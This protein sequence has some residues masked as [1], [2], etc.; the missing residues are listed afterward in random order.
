MRRDRRV[1][2]GDKMNLDRLVENTNYRKHAP[3][4]DTFQGY[5]YVL[6]EGD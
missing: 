6:Q 1:L 5:N 3:F 4:T 2:P